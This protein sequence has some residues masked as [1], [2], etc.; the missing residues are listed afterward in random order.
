M[1][2][3]ALQLNA[4][5]KRHQCLLWRFLPDGSINAVIFY[6]EDANPPGASLLAIPALPESGAASTG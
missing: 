1:V 2:R 4:R 5:T 3:L 6:K